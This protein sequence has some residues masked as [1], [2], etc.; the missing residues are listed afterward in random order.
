[1]NESD[2]KEAERLLDTIDLGHG[3]DEGSLFG[4]MYLLLR[5]LAAQP[6][7]APMTKAQILTIWKDVP[8]IDAERG[9]V[10]YARAIETHHG[11]GA[12]ID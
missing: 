5:R 11:I 7:Q 4:R 12:K 1:M 10:I 3:I 9:G 2:R 6:A 8:N